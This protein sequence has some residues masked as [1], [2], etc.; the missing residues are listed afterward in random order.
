MADFTPVAFTKDGV[1]EIAYSQ[2]EYVSYVFEGWILG[3]TA[4]PELH[5]VASTTVQRIEVVDVLPA[6]NPDD[7]GTLYFVETS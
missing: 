6:P 1:T 4:P 3:D 7:A 5:S 2:A